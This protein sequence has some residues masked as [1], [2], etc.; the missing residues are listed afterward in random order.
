MLDQET[1]EFFFKRL[2][3]FLI[4]LIRIAFWVIFCDY[5]LHYIYMNNLLMNLKLIESF[6]G[7]QLYGLG[8]LMGLFFYIKYICFY[9]IGT[10]FARNMDG[11]ETPKMPKCIGRIHLYSDMWKNF[12]QGLYEFLFL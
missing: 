3:T 6:N 9:G 5:A 8:Y 10:T 2:K 4:F 11:I 1:S 7:F 12:D